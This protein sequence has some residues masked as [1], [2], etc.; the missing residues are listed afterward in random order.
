MGWPVAGEV[1]PLDP[2]AAIFGA[3]GLLSRSFP[4]YSPREG[5]VAMARMANDVLRDARGDAARRLRADAMVL[6][7]AWYEAGG[8]A[9]P[10]DGAG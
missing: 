2:I 6:A 9:P 4:G 1:I 3:T 8:G 5:Q 7:R 10:Q